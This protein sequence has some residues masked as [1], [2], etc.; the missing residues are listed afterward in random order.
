MSKRNS[1]PNARSTVYQTS[2]TSAAS[3][4]ETMKR[5]ADA[6]VA[7]L[8][9]PWHCEDVRFPEESPYPSATG[10]FVTRYSPAPFQVTN[11]GV[12]IANRFMIGMAFGF[13]YANGGTWTFTLTAKDIGVAGET[14]ITA[15]HPR[16]ADFATNFIGMRRV[17][18]GVKLVNTA[19][20]IDRGGAMFMTYT[21]SIPTGGVQFTDDLYNAVETQMYDPARLE[22]EGMQAVYLPITSRPLNLVGDI[23]S[24]PACSYVNPSAIHAA[25]TTITDMYIV[26]WATANSADAL[27][28][29]FEQTDNYEAL[30]YPETEFLFDRT[31]V[32]SSPEH[33][34]VA[35]ERMAPKGKAV[36]TI[37]N[38]EGFWSD[39]KGAAKSAGSHVVKQVATKAIHAISS[40]P[41]LLFGQDFANHKLACAL[42]RLDLS[43]S[44]DLKVRGLSRGA[45]LSLLRR[46]A[47]E[48]LDIEDCHLGVEVPD[49]DAVVIRRV[50]KSPTSQ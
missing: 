9:D 6:Y 26:V 12:P 2:K 23:V 17:S 35:M 15:G 33:V 13:D 27:S 16:N 32:K 49:D 18:M 22:K 7:A 31:A 50:K 38:S 3:V 30:P 45:Y 28:L 8:F 19:P 11:G 39:V 48:P 14:W 5:N 20:L 41:S 47:F 25:R 44:N 4:T 36:S 42:G 40:L 46:K 34:A 37:G 10:K 1:K 29:L 24:L 21:M 43:P